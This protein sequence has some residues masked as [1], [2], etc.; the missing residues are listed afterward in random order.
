MILGK[1]NPVIKLANQIDNFTYTEVTGSYIGAVAERYILGDEGA[2]FEVFFGNLEQKDGKTKFNVLTR[3]GI[4]LSAEDIANWG[5]DDSVVLKKIAELSGT[6]V[7]QVVSGS[8]D[9][10]RF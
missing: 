7:T 6:A 2:R 9:F 3:Q 5:T 1:I 10:N 8:Y 4:Q